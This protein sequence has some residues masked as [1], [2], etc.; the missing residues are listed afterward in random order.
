MQ[1]EHPRPG[2]RVSA[3]ALVQ[4][5][6]PP[7]CALAAGPGRPGA[8][9]PAGTLITIP[10]CDSSPVL[11]QAPR[12]ITGLPATQPQPS[13]PAQFSDSQLPWCPG[14][15]LAP[16]NFVQR[17]VHGAVFWNKCVLPANGYLL[18]IENPEL[19]VTHKD[20]QVQGLTAPQDTLKLNYTSKSIVQLLLEYQHAWG[21]RRFLGGACSTA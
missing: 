9:L 13:P 3:P 11:S 4:P 2:A 21:R 14:Y 16:A 7:V 8:V 19:K 18:I 10:H 5:S 1:G 12:R 15:S 20:R 6:L 17:S